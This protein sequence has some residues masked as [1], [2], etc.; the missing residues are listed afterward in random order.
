MRYYPRTQVLLECYTETLLKGFSVGHILA[1]LSLMPPQNKCMT[2]LAIV[3]WC[4]A[5]SAPVSGWWS[6]CSLSQVLLR[7]WLVD[8]FFCYLK[9]KVCLF[10]K[11]LMTLN[12]QRGEVLLP[13][14]IHHGNIC[15][16][17]PFFTNVNCSCR[18]KETHLKGQQLENLLPSDLTS[19]K[20]VTAVWILQPPELDYYV[21]L[22]FPSTL[23]I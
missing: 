11:P 1:W 21:M 14:H 13:A 10:Q 3:K 12:V 9:L 22:L 17:E 4:W 6:Q 15:Q 2:P 16:L 8:W 18:S 7:L 19:N 23:R 20:E 5:C